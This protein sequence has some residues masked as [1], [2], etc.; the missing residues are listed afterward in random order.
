MC[1]RVGRKFPS[2]LNSIKSR[3]NVA[4]SI[5]SCSL[6][7]YTFKRIFNTF[8]FASVTHGPLK[9]CLLKALCH[10][11]SLRSPF[12]ILLKSFFF[13]LK[14]EVSFAKGK[15]TLSWDVRQALGT[16]R[17]LQRPHQGKLCVKQWRSGSKSFNAQSGIG[18]SSEYETIG[19]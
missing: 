8:V 10:S 18:V 16:A 14:Q 13:P 1:G 2:I 12:T 15:H 3:G 19:D 5:P 7:S 9:C 4:K 6:N 17:V 11:Q